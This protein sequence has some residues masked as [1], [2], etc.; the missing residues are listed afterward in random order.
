MLGARRAHRLLFRG[1]P[2]ARGPPAAGRGR[3][4]HDRAQLRRRQR[5]HAPAGGRVRARQ[6]LATLENT[7]Q[8]IA[9]DQAR[10]GYENTKRR[11]ERRR[12]GAAGVAA[13]LAEAARAALDVYD[14]IKSAEEKSIDGEQ[15]VVR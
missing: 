15:E 9:L 7:D 5:V 11:V 12:V 6:L 3:P 4:V 8:A 13:D 2:R 14:A 1:R 10:H